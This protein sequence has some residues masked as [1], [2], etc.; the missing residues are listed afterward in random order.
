MDGSIRPIG[1]AGHNSSPLSVQGLHVP[2]SL[3]RPPPLF[4]RAAAAAACNP[5]MERGYPRTPKC[6]RCRNHGVVSA[7]KGHKR[8]CRW[9]DCVCAKCTLIAERQ[10]VM[11]AQVALRRQQAQEESEARE[12]QFMYT[13]SGAGETGLHIASPGLPGS[14]NTASKTS[15]YDVLGIE[16]HKDDEKRTKYNFGFIGRPVYAPHLASLPSPLAKNDTSPSLEKARAALDKES[17]SQSPAFDQMSDHIESP[18]SLSS[19][20]LESGS[21]SERPKE[22][23]TLEITAPG[24]ASKDRDPTDVMTK[25]FPHHKRD[26][27]ESVVKTCKGDIVKAIELVLSS[28]ENKCNLDGVDLSTSVPSHTTR[29]TFGLQGALGS[30]G[31]KSAF[32]A[33]APPAPVAAE[34]MYGLSP[35]FGIS[36]LRVAYSAAGGGIPNFMSPYVTSGLMPAFPFRSPL[37]YSFPGMMR[38]LSYLHSKDSLCSTSPYS[39]LSDDK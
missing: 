26:T 7:L 29:P 37:D 24:C 38:D 13:G 23:P 21:E 17:G 30:L 5:S 4:L 22:Y 33:L 3:M 1:L 12:L 25:I 9:R 31:T 27:L 15:T 36:P 20:E 39:R 11:A 18:R 16:D 19:S 14:I 28:K 6:A 35:R 34:S 2:A 32:S 10:R 8:F